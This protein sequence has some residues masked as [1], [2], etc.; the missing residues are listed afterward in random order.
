MG[1]KA[2]EHDKLTNHYHLLEEKKELDPGLI[3]TQQ[4]IDLVRYSWERVVDLHHATD[5]QTTSPVQAFGIAF[6]DALFD[7]DP[8]TRTFFGDNILVQARV[9]TGIISFLV[10]APMVAQHKQT[11][12][13]KEMNARKR[14]Q[15]KGTTGSDKDDDD[16]MDREWWAR[17][18]HKLGARHHSYKVKPE[19]FQLVGP[20]IDVALRVRLQDEYT[21][22]I[23][24][25]W[26]KAHAYVAHHMALG[27]VSQQQQLDIKRSS[28]LIQP[29]SSSSTP[30]SSNCILQ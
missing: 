5:N 3:P 7:L 9:L 1:L 30:L 26:I 28:S 21:N 13:I 25:A 6:Y 4:D 18:L 24:K 22:D 11:T 8:H 29:S 27:L 2:T 20:A 16:E 12:S 23:G 10:R 17:K 15:Q 14:E 19:Q